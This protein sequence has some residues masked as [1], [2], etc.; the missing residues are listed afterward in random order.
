MSDNLQ[1]KCA[2]TLI[3]GNGVNRPGATPTLLELGISK[4]E[5]DVLVAAGRA[6]W[7]D[8]A[9][10]VVASAPVDDGTQL[11]DLASATKAD[12]PAAKT[13]TPLAKMSKAELVDIATEKLVP[14]AAAMTK[15]ELIAAIEALSQVAG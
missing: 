11:Y 14:G 6:F 3:G 1:I 2:I 8:P 10:P 9:A 13:V 7:F 12:E 4:A 15:P 5:A